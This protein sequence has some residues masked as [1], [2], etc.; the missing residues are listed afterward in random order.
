MYGR[1]EGVVGDL[2]AVE[3]VFA[4]KDLMTRLGVANLDCRHDG[5]ALDPA[6]GRASY[7][8][9]AGIA[10]IEQAQFIGAEAELA[11]ANANVPIIFGDFSAYIIAQRTA[12]STKVLRERYADVDKTGIIH[13]AVGK[14]SFDAA[15]LADHKWLY[16]RLGELGLD[17]GAALDDQQDAV[18]A[19]RD[20]LATRLQH[21]HHER[22]VHRPD[23]VTVLGAQHPLGVGAG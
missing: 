5:A 7:L 11:A 8:F 6:W 1:A 12:I 2:A 20:A 17:T 14:V 19:S 18:G 4:L 16:Y 10:G 22:G 21:P 3:E 13:C 23:E 9:N 15:K